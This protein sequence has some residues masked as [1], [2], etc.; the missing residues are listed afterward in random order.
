[1]DIKVGPSNKI[2]YSVVYEVAFNPKVKISLSPRAYASVKKSRNVI[3]R[4]LE[5]GKVVYGVTTGFGNFKNKFISKEDAAELQVNLIRSHSTGVGP[6]LSKE[7]VRAALFVRLNSLVQGYSGVRVELLELLCGLLNKDIIPIV[8]SQGSVGSSGDLAPLSHMGL[9]LMGEGEALYK[10]RIMPGGE[11][12][13]RASL[14]PITFTAKE[15]LA[16]NN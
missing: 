8:P 7:A 9:V 10:G 16:W 15:G 5:K 13:K 4:M 14:K 1:M 2:N 11:A 12:L 3:E 6:P